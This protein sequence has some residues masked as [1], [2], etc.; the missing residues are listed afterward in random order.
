MKI[1]IVYSSI[2]HG[3]TKKVVEAIKDEIGVELIKVKEA[4]SKDL[5]QYEGIFNDNQW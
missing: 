1:A 5:S 4:S 2:H 3:N